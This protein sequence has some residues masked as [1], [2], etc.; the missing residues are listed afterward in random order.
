MTP[1]FPNTP[2]TPG[3]LVLA[4]TE[5]GARAKKWLAVE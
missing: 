3:V 4:N 1:F 5:S 2:Y